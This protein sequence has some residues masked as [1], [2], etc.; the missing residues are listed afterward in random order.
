M[1]FVRVFVSPWLRGSKI[2]SRGDGP[3]IADE[4]QTAQQGAGGAGLAWGQDFAG[5]DPSA[6]AQLSQ[7]RELL[8]A[9][10][11]RRDDASNAGNNL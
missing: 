6:Q 7:A 2:R 10:R 8:A 4:T 11:D 3:R 1:K 9:L 5:T